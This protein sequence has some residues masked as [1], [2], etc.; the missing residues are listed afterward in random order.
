MIVSNVWILAA[1]WTPS[2]CRLGLLAHYIRKSTNLFS[3]AHAPKPSYP[4]PIWDQLVSVSAMRWH[5]CREGWHFTSLRTET[6]ATRRWLRWDVTRCKNGMPQTSKKHLRKTFAES[7]LSPPRSTLSPPVPVPFSVQSTDPFTGGL[8]RDGQRL[9]GAAGV[10]LAAAATQRYRW[11]LAKFLMWAPLMFMWIYIFCGDVDFVV[12]LFSIYFSSPRPWPCTS[13]Q[14]QRAWQQN[15]LSAY[16][17]GR[18]PLKRA[19]GDQ[20]GDMETNIEH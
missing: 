1:Q 18:L 8:G 19:S 10:V 6:N 2:C 13:S 7:G 20:P 16:G 11:F 3:V 5:N 17:T 15:M 12:V 4:L 9:W 14:N